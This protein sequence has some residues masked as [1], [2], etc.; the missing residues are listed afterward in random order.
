MGRFKTK[1]E[2][3]F[4]TSTKSIIDFTCDSTYDIKDSEATITIHHSG[5]DIKFTIKNFK[6]G[7]VELIFDLPDKTLKYKNK[8][9]IG[10]NLIPK[11]FSSVN[12]LD[13]KIELIT[14]DDVDDSKPFFKS[15]TNLNEYK[16]IVHLDCFKIE[17]YINST[18]LFSFNNTK[19]LA[20]LFDKDKDLKSNS[21]DFTYHGITKCVGLPERPSHLLLDDNHYRM[22]NTDDNDQKVGNTQPTYGSIPMLHGI[23]KDHIVTV[24]NSNASDQWVGLKTINNSDRQIE[25]I[26]EGGIIDLYLFSDND[27]MRNLEKVAKVTGYAPLAPLSIFGYH[28]CRWGYADE[29]DIIG[30]AKKFDEYEIPYDVFWMDIEHTNDKRYF[31]WNPNGFSHTKEFIQKLHDDHRN[32]V[33]IVDPHIKKDDAYEV[34]KIL[35][36]KDCFV[37]KKDDEGNL[38]PYIG[39]C[40]PGTSYYAD[41]INYE[42]LLPLY[43]Q[44]FK[45]E[46]YFFGFDNIYTWVD[47]NEPSVFDSEEMTMP[48]TNLHF[49]GTQLV[50]HKE[51]HNIYGYFYQKVA[52][53][54]LKN[55]FDNKYRP[56]ILSRSYYAGS[57]QNSFI[58]TGDNKATYEFMNNGIE[59]NIINGLCGHSSCGSDVGGFINNPSAQL[60][61]DWYSFGLFYMFFRGHSAFDTIRREPWLFGDDVLNSIKNS[62]ILRYHI[63]MFIYTKFYEYTQTGVSV[64][65]PIWM[66]F[67]EQFNELINIKDNS[68]LFVLGKEIIGVNEYTL[69]ETGAKFLNSLKTPL[70]ELESGCRATNFSVKD[71]EQK[72]RKIVIGGKIIPWT[73]EVK[74]CAYNVLR[75]PLS[76][77]VFVDENKKAKGYYYMDD[78]KTIEL[79]GHFLY[80]QFVFNNGSIKIENLNTSKEVTNGLIKDIIPN[81]NKIEVYGYGKE[82]KVAKVNGK[83][84]PVTYN[85]E[86]DM[87]VL[88]LSALKIKVCELVNASLE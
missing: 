76:I 5:S 1:E 81:W 77:K 68:S 25:W 42:K 23:N 87:A 62:I 54:S 26:T 14:K 86:T 75:S 61:K 30:V 64:L 82:A 48:K 83:D 46:D 17:Y 39:H 57:Q 44:F 51:V 6:F 3:T 45:N 80:L 15:S 8:T 58:W 33:T 88:D 4:Y 60:M 21:F 2:C 70:Y 28:Q 24:F 49:D 19:S 7:I 52:Y 50:E 71:K 79:E 78:G 47:M 84:V 12:D 10:E 53:N 37:K 63:L 29:D 59:T 22:F 41:F 11:P 72:I 36:E 69:C 85:K 35:K 27:Y 38:V 40:W 34:C 32:V 43:K 13:N 73:D 65:K 56:F 66:V 9:N 74:K 16:I 20:L 55:R 31:T 18:L 67:K